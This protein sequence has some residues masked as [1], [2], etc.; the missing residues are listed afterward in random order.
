MK[1]F[2]GINT[3]TM[4]LPVFPNSE[5]DQHKIISDMHNSIIKNIDNKDKFESIVKEY[6][7]FRDKHI[8]YEEKKMLDS[9]YPK[10]ELHCES[11]LR[12]HEVEDSLLI[13]GNDKSKIEFGFRLWKLHIITEDREMMEWFSD[14]SSFSITD[15]GI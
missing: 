15:N 11:H 2:L 10:L 8:E 4:V 5:K 14:G 6:K 13:F 12:M 3:D 7:E 9:G 1:Q